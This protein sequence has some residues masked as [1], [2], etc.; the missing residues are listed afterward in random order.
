[1]PIRRL[2]S[3]I[4]KFARA[5]R[6]ATAVEFGLIC[7]PLFML[8]C[9]TMELGGVFLVMTTLDTATESAARTIRTG[10]FQQGSAV[11]KADFKTLVCKNTTW[12]QSSCSSDAYVEAQTFASYATMAANQP[13]V[14]QPLNTTDPALNQ[15][16]IN[17]KLATT[18]FT[19]GKP[20]DIVLVRV[21]YRWKLFTPGL[22]GALDNIGGGVRLI[23]S[24]TAFRNEP[25]N[26]TPAQ[27]AKCT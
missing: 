24:T 9:G 25:Y 14:T 18:C 12:L 20:G 15:Q 5:E 8:I 19:P 26:D 21:Y 13:V 17:T 10:Q 6:G 2:I 4:G 7:V 1:V 23:T 16:Q 11:A 3:A 22:D 27:G